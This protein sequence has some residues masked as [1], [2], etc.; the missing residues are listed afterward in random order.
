MSEDKISL[1]LYRLELIDKNILEVKD[2]FKVLN[3]KVQ[4]VTNWK[5]QNEEFV[6]DLKNHEGEMSEYKNFLKGMMNTSN[7]IK[8]RLISKAVDFIVFLIAGGTGFV[9]VD[10][11]IK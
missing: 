9:L 10:K 2:Q 3:G 1:I 7:S 8:D 6:C 4:D 5:L 11:L